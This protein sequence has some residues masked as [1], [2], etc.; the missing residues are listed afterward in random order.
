MQYRVFT[1]FLLRF[2]K[3]TMKRESLSNAV[4]RFDKFIWN[5]ENGKNLAITH[6][7]RV[8]TITFVIFQECCIIL[9]QKETFKKRCQVSTVYIL[10]YIH[11]LQSYKTTLSIK[12]LVHTFW[13]YILFILNWYLCLL[14]T[15]S[16][17][18]PDSQES[19]D[20]PDWLQSVKS[21]DSSE[22]PESS[23]LQK[24]QNQ[25]ISQNH[26]G[27]QNHNITRITRI[28]R[29]TRMTWF[30]RISR[31]TKITI[32]LEITRITQFKKVSESSDFLEPESPIS[33]DSPE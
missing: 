22:I 10:I 21:P 3:W 7:R 11:K 31:F 15:D 6:A 20:L 19:P 8:P 1:P 5:I 32:F 14:K 30:T 29:F 4:L 27:Q 33:L 9:Y 2:W 17:E 24:Y 13:F 25:Q 18:T 12:E 28:A 23:N 26:Q 16:P